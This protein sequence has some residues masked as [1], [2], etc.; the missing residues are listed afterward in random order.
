M[1]GRKWLPD[2]EIEAQ[3]SGE[4]CLR[5]CKWVGSQG[6]SDFQFS[7]D[8]DSEIPDGQS[9]SNVLGTGWW[10]ASSYAYLV[11]LVSACIE[12]LL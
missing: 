4:T 9:I 6:G 2:K 10:Q 3:S 1:A 7:L 12:S 5:L 11:C 8:W